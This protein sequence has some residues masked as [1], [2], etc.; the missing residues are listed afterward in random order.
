MWG[1]YRFGNHCWQKRRG[2]AG[3]RTHDLE[4]VAIVVVA[5]DAL[6]SGVRGNDNRRLIK[7]LRE[8]AAVERVLRAKASVQCTKETQFRVHLE[9]KPVKRRD[10][11]EKETKR[12]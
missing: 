10:F 5:I 1:R 6:D 3:I 7:D 4:V 11:E 12:R 2:A 8:N 9:G